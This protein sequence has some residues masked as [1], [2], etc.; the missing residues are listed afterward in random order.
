MCELRQKPVVFGGPNSQKI[1]KQADGCRRLAPAL[2]RSRVACRY[3]NE[4]ICLLF[5]HTLATATTRMRARV[6]VP[7]F[8]MFCARMHPLCIMNYG[9]T[10][11]VQYSMMLR[12]NITPPSCIRPVQCYSTR[13][14]SAALSPPARAPPTRRHNARRRIRIR[15]PLAA[16]ADV[17]T[18]YS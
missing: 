15:I 6:R 4:W 18:S 14:F 9:F 3:V 7:L 10:R 8:S 12:A 17:P 5:T 11:R 2:Y 13:V 1:R 16:R